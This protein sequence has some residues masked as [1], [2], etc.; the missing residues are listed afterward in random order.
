MDHPHIAR[1]LDVG[2]TESG[3]PYFVMELVQGVPITEFCDQHHLRT[4]ER[5][6]LFVHVC[7]AIQHAHQKGIIH[8]D[9]KPSNVLVTV[10]DGQSVPKVIDFGVAKAIDQ[11]FPQHD[12][13]TLYAQTI[14][15]PL[16]MSPEQAE[17][18]CLDVDTRTDVY[19]L[20]VLL[21]ELLTGS[22]PF[23]LERLRSVGISE[24]RR[25][26]RE[27]EPPRA[28]ERVMTH[29][30][31]CTSACPKCQGEPR[32]L[33][34]TLRGELDC[35]VATAIDKDRARRYDSAGSF[36]ADVQRYLNDEPIQ[37]RPAT[38]A[39]HA[40]KWLCRHPAAA[41]VF[42][43]LHVFVTILLAA[44]W[45]FYRMRQALAMSNE[46]RETSQANERNLA[47]QLYATDVGIAWQAWLDGDLSQARGLLNRYGGDRGLSDMCGFEW[48]LLRRNVAGPYRT[49]VGHVSPIL[50]AVVSPDQRWMASSGRSGEIIIWDFATGRELRTLRYGDKEVT[51]LSVSPDGRVLATAGQD[52]TV[53]LWDTAD[54]P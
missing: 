51:S 38:V 24:M 39:G 54:K 50:A 34:Q 21:F 25:I 4:R 10:N 23:E 49:L 53:R 14:G 46:L 47:A 16:Y 28:S 9:I 7:R 3:R 30:A 32:R 36:A 26:L 45:H 52:Q 44:T 17:P 22:T 48:R 31:S 5:L 37:A 11:S 27:E 33:S 13:R 1:V 40:R 43:V 2:T 6:A 18:G 35:I 12:V 29:K 20:G 8:R 42:V 41:F 15:T 19:S